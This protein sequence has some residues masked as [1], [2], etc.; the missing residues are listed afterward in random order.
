LLKTLLKE[1]RFPSK[2]YR[3]EDKRT[4]RV[5]WPE[6]WPQARLDRRRK[7]IGSVAMEREFN[8]NPIDPATQPFKAAYFPYFAPGELPV[9]LPHFGGVDPAISLK[10][11]ASRFALAEIATGAGAIWVVDIYLDRI[12]FRQQ[13]LRVIDFCRRTGAIIGVEGV[14]Y[15]RALAEQSA[16]EGDL[17]HVWP[18]VKP[19]PA[20]G[21][22]DDRVM[23]LQ[24]VAERGGIRFAEHLKPLVEGEL[25]LWPD[26]GKDAWDAIYHAVQV[27]KKSGVAVEV[28]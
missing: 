16:Y 8:Q 13:V 3:A 7:Q 6:W 11:T 4:G 20:I 18:A 23:T 19:V 12:T 21:S 24:P 2:L 15:Q 5:L 9:G 22:K 1:E 10:R 26:E 27:S 14:A 17:A 25:I 28:I